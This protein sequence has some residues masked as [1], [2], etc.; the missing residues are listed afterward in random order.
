MDALEREAILRSMIDDL[1]GRGN[2]RKQSIGIV[3]NN[4]AAAAR[5]AEQS[6]VNILMEA[7]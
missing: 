4:L 1:I 6:L 5:A 3:K 7:K 2:S